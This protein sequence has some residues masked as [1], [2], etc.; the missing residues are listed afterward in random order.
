M[1]YSCPRVDYFT[2][3]VNFLSTSICLI[4]SKPY[5]STPY[6]SVF[7]SGNFQSSFFLGSFVTL[8][9]KKCNMV[10]YRTGI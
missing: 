9:P 7:A 8:T 4:F 10:T 3:N 1:F 2:V 5:D 6:D